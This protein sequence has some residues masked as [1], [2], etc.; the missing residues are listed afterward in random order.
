MLSVRT[1][2]HILTAQPIDACLVPVRFTTKRAAVGT[3]D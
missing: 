2:A 1:T 3:P